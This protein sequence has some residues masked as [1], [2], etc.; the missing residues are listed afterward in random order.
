MTYF[1]T[2]SRRKFIQS[3]AMNEVDA[4][5]KGGADGT[6]GE[7]KLQAALIP[8]GMKRQAFR[9]SGHGIGQSLPRHQQQRLHL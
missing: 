9:Y 1:A 8:A 2:R 7:E 5:G 3:K 6:E 4:G